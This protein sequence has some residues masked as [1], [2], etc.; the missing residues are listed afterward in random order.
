MDQNIVPK[1]VERL[2]YREKD[3]VL[4]DTEQGKLIEL[5][6]SGNDI[7]QFCSEGKTVK[8]IIDFLKEKY[9]AEPIENISEMVYTF[10]RQA[11]E[12][13]FIEF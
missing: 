11:K 8:E 9:T 4:F 2:I 7:V 10:L 12:A 3:A 1:I 13:A 5:N 6:L